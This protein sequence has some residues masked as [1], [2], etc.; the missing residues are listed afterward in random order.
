MPVM[1]HAYAE[2]DGKPLRVVR[3][4][5]QPGP[6]G[7]RRAQG[8]HAARWWCRCSGRRASWTSRTSSAATTSSSWARAT[9]RW[10]RCLPGRQHHPD[11][12]R[13]H[14]HG[15]V[16]AA[17]DARPGHDRGH[18]RDR[19]PAGTHGAE[20]ERLR[21]LGVQKVMTM[22][23]TYDHRV[24]QGAESGR[25]P[26]PDRRA[27]PGRGRLLRRR[28][29]RAGRGR[30]APRPASRAAVTADEPVPAAARAG[31]RAG[32]RC[33]LLC[34]PCRRPPRWS[35][36]HRM[37]GHLAARL[38]P[39]GSTPLGD[40]GARPRDREAH[41]RADAAHPGVGAA[42]GGARR[43][44]R[45]RAAPA[46]RDLHRARSPTR[47]STSPTTSSA[48]GCARPSSRA[49]TASRSTRRQSAAARAPLAGRGARELPAQGVP[50]QEAVLDRGP[51]RAGADAR[52]DDRARIGRRRARGGGRN[53][54]PGPAQRAGAHGRRPYEAIL[55]EFEG[56]QTLAVD[57]AAPE[58]GTGDVK[59]HYGASG[60]YA[61]LSGRRRDR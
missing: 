16:R 45:R 44:L 48:S 6:G 40:P 3:R 53:G 5:R 7:G 25:V 27:A 49:P 12:P 52:R 36:P 21:E 29:R 14:R 24:I 54:P 20:P 55:A 30:R 1:G 58:G 39:L 33:A 22:T 34:R 18:G 26:A 4:R 11:Q 51:R 59:Y 8:R 43:Y 42:R 23:S 10:R 61:N 56:E 41:R 38:D 37:H 50:G 32:G 13:R 17:P 15:G 60:T 2:E 35:R 46:A 57:T 28:V 19:L 47:S 9:T 31:R